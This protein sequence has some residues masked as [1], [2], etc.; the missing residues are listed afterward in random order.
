MRALLVFVVVL[1]GVAAIAV[2]VMYFEVPAHSLPHFVPGY[3]AH[4]TAKHDKR[5]YVGWGIGAFF[6]IVALILGMSG[7]PKRHGS[8]R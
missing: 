2:G 6:L 7:Q 8:L 5:A 3:V 1:L 4:S